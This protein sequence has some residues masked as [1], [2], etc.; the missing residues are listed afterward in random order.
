MAGRAQGPL[1]PPPAFWDASAVVP[2]CV[3][4]KHSASAGSFLQQ[5]RMVVWW[6]TSVEIA[7]ALA[8]LLRMNLLSHAEWVQAHSV[9]SF[10]AREWTE[11][12]PSDGLRARAAIVVGKYDLR[13]ADAFQLAAALEWSEGN[14]AGKTF[15]AADRRLIEAALLSGFDALSL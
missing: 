10:L 2:L 9:A 5:Y 4:E 13:A 1:N 3:N 11:V 12:S 7:G 6:G 15:L 14:P 8:R